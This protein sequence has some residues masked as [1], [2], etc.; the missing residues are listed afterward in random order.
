M[1]RLS[2]NTADF[3]CLSSA[4]LPELLNLLCLSSVN[5]LFRFSRFFVP[6]FSGRRTS[7]RI[8]FGY[9]NMAFFYDSPYT[10]LL[11]SVFSSPG[12]QILEPKHPSIYAR[13]FFHVSLPGKLKQIVS[14]SFHGSSV[15]GLFPHRIVIPL[16]LHVGSMHLADRMKCRQPV[17]CRKYVPR[18][19]F[20]GFGS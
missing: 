20:T 5:L 14:G 10:I 7:L 11:P 13:S 19:F 3:L 9:I 6:P 2:R 1:V 12:E 16:C 8:S 18:S 4:I 17:F 15:S